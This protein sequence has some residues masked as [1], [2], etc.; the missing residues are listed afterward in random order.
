M[1]LVNVKSNM[2]IFIQELKEHDQW[3]NLWDDYEMDIAVQFLKST[4]P[5]SIHKL[6]I[7]ARELRAYMESIK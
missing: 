1:R 7:A 4:D 3:D 6:L 5:Q 2:A